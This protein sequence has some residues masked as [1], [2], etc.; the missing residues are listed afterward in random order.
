MTLAARGSLVA[1]GWEESISPIR[2]N[3]YSWHCLYL[4]FYYTS[5]DIYSLVIF[6]FNNINNFI[7]LS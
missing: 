2:V 3:L 7:E 1:V 6:L 5:L 4:C